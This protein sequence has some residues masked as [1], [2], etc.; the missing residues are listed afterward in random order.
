MLTAK[1]STVIVAAAT[2]SG[3]PSSFASAFGGGAVPRTM[4]RSTATHIPA[5]TTTAE[6]HPLSGR[7]SEVL[8]CPNTPLTMEPEMKPVRTKTINSVNA[9]ICL[10][11]GAVRETQAV[12]RGMMARKSG[13]VETAESVKST[14]SRMRRTT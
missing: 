6:N 2:P 5:E 14:A 7:K 13:E 1:N 9:C 8:I 12:P 4:M 3:F 10:S 11:G